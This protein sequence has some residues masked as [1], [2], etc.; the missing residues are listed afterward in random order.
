MASV[1]TF[2]TAYRPSVNYARGIVWLADAVKAHLPGF[3]LRIYCDG[4][5]DPAKLAAAGDEASARTW[6]QTFAAL[7]AATH[8]NL[9]WYTFEPFAAQGGRGHVDLFG[10]FP[11]FL[12]FFGDSIVASSPGCPLP[13]WAAAPPDG[14]IVFSSDVDYGDFVTEHAMMHALQWYASL[15]MPGSSSGPGIQPPPHILAMAASG[16]TAPRHEPACGLP[17]FYSGLIAARYRLPTRLFDAFIDD[18]VRFRRAALAAGAVDV[19]TLP[20]SAASAGSSAAAAVESSGA[21]TALSA[22]ITAASAAAPLLGR[23]MAAVHDPSRENLTYGRRRVKEQAFLPFGAD[24]YFLTHAIKTAGIAG[25]LGGP[26]R[27]GGASASAAAGSG[28]AAA[29]SEGAASAGSADWLFL[30]VPSIDRELPRPVQLVAEAL[31]HPGASLADGSPLLRILAAAADAAS[32]SSAAQLADARRRWASMGPAE[33]AAA[34]RADLPAWAREWGKAAANAV[35][36]WHAFPGRFAVLDAGAAAPVADGM[37][38]AFA[39]CLAAAASGALPASAEDVALL[40]QYCDHFARAPA[41]GLVAAHHFAVGSGRVDRISVSP[42]ADGLMAALRT[43][44]GCG[45]PR[46]AALPSASAGAAFGFVSPLSMTP[47]AAAAVGGAGSRSSEV[48]A[49]RLTVAPAA[50]ASSSGGATSATSVSASATATSAFLSPAAT[51]A[52]WA[53]HVSRSTGGRYF[54]HAATQRSLWWDASLPLD[55]GWTQ[56]A[57]TAPKQWVHMVTGERRDSSPTATPAAAA[58]ATAAAAVG[59][60]GAAV[61]S[62]AEGAEPAAKRQRRAEEGADA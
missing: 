37:R 1:F 43:A 24:E 53:V 3:T 34:A 58:S 10:T 7:E 2:A 61:D 19:A 52:G 33:A 11:R 50:G 29:I 44:H 62:D 49:P 55:W 9:V 59:G 28:A 31:G 30:I 51:A 21:S 35:S 57:P 25:A 27:R 4:S 38:R 6:A 12:P 17:P 18:C 5:L 22:A 41:P 23:Y 45:V 20:L 14:A 8:V 39:E 54:Y 46:P 15:P 60:A 13:P 32:P 56:A 40:A 26:Q 48:S 16:S 42:L 36:L 47:A